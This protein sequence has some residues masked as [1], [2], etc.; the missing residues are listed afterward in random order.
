[1]REQLEK[2]IDYLSVER[3]LSQNTLSAYRRDINAYSTFLG[4][5]NNALPGVNREKIVS[6]LI[7]LKGKRL[8]PVSI[9][10]A[11]SA[12]KGFHRFL[13]SE[14]YSSE[15]PTLSMKTPSVWTKLPAVL[16]LNEVERLLSK[17]DVSKM[18]GIR[19]RAILELLYATGMRATE[20]ISLKM[21][22][23]NLEVGYI[24]CMGKG[25]KERIIP[26]GRQAI[27]CI[28]TYLSEAR[29]HYSKNKDGILFISRL[30]GP[31]S[32]QS[33]WKIIKKYSKIALLKSEI[34]PHTLRH[35]FATHLLERGADIR[36][37]QEM[38]GHVSISTTQ[39]YTH[40]DRER[41]KV[42]HAR[43]HPRG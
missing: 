24:R 32:R 31:M 38:L 4:K 26:L 11:L 10:R 43:Y 19:D 12:I 41:L 7:R 42:I 20:L 21:T 39:I 25:S 3:G 8:S 28:Q 29:P 5:N 9:A 34:S 13:Y 23:A 33:L 6:Y 22:D 2:F 18:A 15:D 17:P 37:V 14:G 1:M 40:I 35:S 30:G 27:K 36:A 16:S